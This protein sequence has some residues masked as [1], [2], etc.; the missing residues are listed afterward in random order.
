MRG[1]GHGGCL[2]EPVKTDRAVTVYVV[3][4]LMTTTPV[5][6]SVQSRIHCVI[7]SI[8]RLLQNKLQ[9]SRTSCCVV[10]MVLM[11]FRKTFYQATH[12]CRVWSVASASADW[13]IVLCAEIVT[14][15]HVNKLPTVT[16]S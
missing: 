15:L 7:D 5:F 12:I 14:W 10:H 11:F 4:S 1:G 8:N 9:L 16:V 13:L 3:I 6:L 2:S